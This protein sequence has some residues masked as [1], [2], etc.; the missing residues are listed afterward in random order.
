M[1]N[2]Q[3]SDEI[4]R[5]AKDMYALFAEQMEEMPKAKL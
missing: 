5:A 3:F 1:P 4:A 2:E